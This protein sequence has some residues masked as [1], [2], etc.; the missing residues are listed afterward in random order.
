VYWIPIPTAKTAGVEFR[1]QPCPHR[2]SL[3]RK[4]A[5]LTALPPTPSRYR[6]RVG[7][8]LLVSNYGLGTTW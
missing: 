7:L 5:T 2:A 1:A 6:T 4:R 3:T 8:I